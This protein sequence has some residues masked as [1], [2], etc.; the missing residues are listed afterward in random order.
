LS[1]STGRPLAFV[2]SAVLTVVRA[3]IW[4]DTALKGR[5][6]LGQPRIASVSVLDR[7]LFATNIRG[8]CGRRL[9]ALTPGT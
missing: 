9:V 7:S 3:A 1:L 8:L 4:A 2:R 6:M 5:N